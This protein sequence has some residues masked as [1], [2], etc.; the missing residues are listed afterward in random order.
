M[1]ATQL[2][3]QL[4]ALTTQLLA[5]VGLEH[6]PAAALATV[7]CIVL[8]LLLR[9]FLRPAAGTDPSSPGVGVSDGDDHSADVP[10]RLLK[11]GGEGGE[12][13]GRRRREAAEATRRSFGSPSLV[14]V[15]QSGASPT[16]ALPSPGASPESGR[17][18]GWKTI[19]AESESGWRAEQKEMRE[20]DRRRS[21]NQGGGMMCCAR[22]SRP[23]Q[24]HRGL[25]GGAAPTDETCAVVAVQFTEAGSLG[26]QLL[27]LSGAG[28]GGG[29]HRQGGRSGSTGAQTKIKELRPGTQ[30]ARHHAGK[31]RPGM[32]LRTVGTAKVAGMSFDAVRKLIVVST[33]RPIK[34]SFW[35]PTRPTPQRSELTP[36]HRRR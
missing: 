7:A 16:G 29:A 28:G 21:S 11:A 10:D 35:D 30:A 22:P 1:S 34:L 3:Q 23:P 17:R 26:I 36:T 5:A 25:R 20:R 33:G 4:R 13:T 19:G 18:A 27:G 14:S 32:V 24:H 2:E 8:S 15:Q 9:Y 6:V 12:A 31:L